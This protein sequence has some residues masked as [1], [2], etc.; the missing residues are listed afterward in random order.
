MLLFSSGA[1]DMQALQAASMIGATFHYRIPVESRGRSWLLGAQQGLRKSSRIF[2]G[3]LRQQCQKGY[4][5]FAYRF[6]DREGGVI[7]VTH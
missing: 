2:S 7:Q 4:N 3:S 6:E 5:S 1:S